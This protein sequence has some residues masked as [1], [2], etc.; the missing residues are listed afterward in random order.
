[1]VREAHPPAQSKASRGLPPK[2]PFP[3]LA[4]S[5]PSIQSSPEPV[6]PE[7]SSPVFLPPAGP[8]TPVRHN[9]PKLM[10]TKLFYTPEQPLR[11]NLF[12]NHLHGCPH[13]DAHLLGMADHPT[14]L[15][16]K[17]RARLECN[18]AKLLGKGYDQV[19]EKRD[20]TVGAREMD[21]LPP[22][23]RGRVL[24]GKVCATLSW[25][26]SPIK[27]CDDCD[28]QDMIETGSDEM[29]D[30]LQYSLASPLPERSRSDA[31]SPYSS[32][33]KGSCENTT[34]HGGLY[35][36]DE[37]NDADVESNLEQS[38]G[39]YMNNLTLQTGFS[40]RVATFT[41]VTAD[42][43]SEGREDFEPDDDC[44][45]IC[46]MEYDTEMEVEPQA[47]YNHQNQDY[48]E[49]GSS[50][51]KGDEDGG[52]YFNFG[53]RQQSDLDRA[54]LTASAGGPKKA[55]WYPTEQLAQ[56]SNILRE[57]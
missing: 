14:P 32:T 11:R 4:F 40:S 36:D 57:D 45:T 31:P 48:T 52:G 56:E 21:G 22:I 9:L 25:S 16:S 39:I 41:S 20:N 43:G 15:L 50:E 49:N 42:G 47:D 54:A 29:E 46:D 53:R 5:E 18:C 35:V 10:T 2:T 7:S 28:Y 1:M 13:N 23:G 27:G 38:P 34:L 26:S 6:P 17:R 19:E 3:V 30:G 24:D 51:Y 55:L 12:G 8:E 33:W 37:M 44:D